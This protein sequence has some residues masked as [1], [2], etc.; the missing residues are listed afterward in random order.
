MLQTISGFATVIVINLLV[1]WI[2]TQSEFSKIS[3]IL[4]GLAILVNLMATVMPSWFYELW[5]LKT[6]K[7]IAYAVGFWFCFAIGVV[8]GVSV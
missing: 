1:Y 8:L 6:R 5:G 3:V 4:L 2:K 7:V